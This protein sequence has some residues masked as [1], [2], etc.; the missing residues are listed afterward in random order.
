V[1][2]NLKR[3]DEAIAQ[4]NQMLNHSKLTDAQKAET[5]YYLGL[6]LRDS[7]RSREAIAAFDEALKLKPDYRA[8]EE[9]KKRL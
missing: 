9:A 3:F 4:F 2:R 8:A 7:F 5:W 1:L 6:T